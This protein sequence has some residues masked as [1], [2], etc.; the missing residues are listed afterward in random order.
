MRLFLTIFF[1]IASVSSAQQHQQVD[2]ALLRQYYAQ[3]AEQTGAQ[4]SRAAPIYESQDQ[5]QYAPQ[6]Q[7]K[8]VSSTLPNSAT[9]QS[10]R[11][12]L[13]ERNLFI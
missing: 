13:Q 2:P 10:K 4:Q 12:G 11:V 7:L 9:L 3:L 5:P 8:N 1:A 6:Q